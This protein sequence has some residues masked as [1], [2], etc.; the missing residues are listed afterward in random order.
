[1]L[2][3]KRNFLVLSSL[4][5]G[6]SHLGS[7]PAQAGAE[8]EVDL[9]GVSFRWQHQDNLLIGKLSAPTNGWIAVG[10][11]NGPG[12]ADTYFIMASVAE[13]PQ[14]FEERY[15]IVPDH[16]RISELGWPEKA[17]LTSGESSGGSS[18][19]TFT[20]PSQGPVGSGISLEAG[21]KVYLMLA[22]SRDADFAHHSA[23]RRHLPVSL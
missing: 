13:D 20:M 4:A 19:V 15:A 18:T 21:N 5:L 14:R 16:L 2:M 22:W 17:A 23:W 12:I 8:K 1:M 11:S 3:S 7:Q 10:F 6:A 9:D